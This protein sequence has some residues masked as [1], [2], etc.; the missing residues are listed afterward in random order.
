MNLLYKN[1][2]II[3]GPYLIKVTENEIINIDF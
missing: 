3:T 1:S 2:G